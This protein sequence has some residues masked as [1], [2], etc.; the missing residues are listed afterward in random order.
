MAM[1][2]VS[3]SLAAT[4]SPAPPLDLA[5]P[6]TQK[7]LAQGVKDLYACRADLKVTTGA[8]NTCIA[9]DH[10]TISWWQEPL[11]IGGF[12]ISAGV[13]GLLLGLAHK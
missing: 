4:P 7:I 8:Y 9:M 5:S 10:P 6:L 11:V 12:A 13:A 3:S 1:C 2:L